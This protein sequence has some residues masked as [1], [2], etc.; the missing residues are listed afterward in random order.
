[1]PRS[2]ADYGNM[3]T[4]GVSF[5]EEAGGLIALDIASQRAAA[6]IYTQGAHVCNWT[7]SGAEPVLFV[8]RE[9]HFAP[10]KAIRGGVPVCFPGFAARAGRPD[11]PAHGFLRT[12][13][14][15]IESLNEENGVV[16]IEFSASSNDATR[17]QWPNDFSVRYFIEVG[18]ILDLEFQVENTGNA[19][20]TFEAALHTYLAVSDVRTVSVAG[21]E[22]TEYIDKVDAGARKRLK[23]EPL[24][25][26]AETD[27]VFLNTTSTCALHDPGLK[28]TISVSKGGSSTTVVWNPWIVKAAAMADFGNSEWPQMLC[29]ETAN[30]GENAVSLEAGKVHTMAAS[31][32]VSD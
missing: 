17:A 1:M 3:A 27:R 26:T 20:F 12:T 22:D 18:T 10:G 5:R 28:R 21:L 4:P 11:S 7:P 14:W 15:N 2:A 8:S 31:I 24:R 16:R 6:R 25:F 23:N 30:A 29:I 13:E 32:S 19:P 9:S